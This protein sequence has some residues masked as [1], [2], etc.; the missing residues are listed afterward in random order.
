MAVVSVII[1]C[2]NAE[3]YIEVCLDALSKQTFK[4]FDVILIDDC[5]LDNTAERIE[6]YRISHNLDIKYMR[7]EVNSGPSKS[8]HYGVESTDSEYVAFCDS[9]DWYEADF[10]Q[11]MI[12]E[13]RKKSA[14]IVF[15][16]MQKVLP[17][18]TKIKS[19]AIGGIVSDISVSEALS[20]GVDSMCTMLIKRDIV[21]DTPFIDIRNGEDMAMVPLMIIRSAKFGAVRDCLYNYFCRPGSAS[22]F[23]DENVVRSLEQSFDFIYNNR[24]IRYE[25]EIE[26]VG[27][28][29]VVYG[30]LLNHFK[31]STVKEFARRVLNEFEKKY[32][33]WAKNEYVN[34][35]TV[36]KKLF[37]S[38]AKR[39]MFFGV[40]CLC[41]IHTFLTGSEEG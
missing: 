20:F 28:K 14:D 31:Y 30:V 4:D 17:N 9:D 37:V 25:K 15:C 35:L 8:R 19:D 10:L 13:A 29:N 18:G 22:L 41:K 34:K 3:N 6:K 23:V 11:K 21:V 7:N 12:G 39:R 38:L 16:N 24:D 27:I 2:Y 33:E 40:K 26:F 1:P 32:P 36:F 5:S